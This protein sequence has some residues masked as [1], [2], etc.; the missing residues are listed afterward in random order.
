MLSKKIREWGFNISDRQFQIIQLI[1]TIGLIITIIVV[2]ITI[3]KYA[4]MLKLDPCILCNKS[5]I[6]N[7]SYLLK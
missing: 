2:T 7:I 4:D 5:S 3:L 6:E 1:F